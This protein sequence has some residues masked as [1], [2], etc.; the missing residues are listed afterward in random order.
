MRRADLEFIAEGIDWQLFRCVYVPEDHRKLVGRAVANAMQ[1][2]SAALGGNVL[3]EELT[4]IAPRVK[5]PSFEEED[6]WR[7][8]SPVLPEEF[9]FSYRV[10]R[11]TPV[12]YVPLP[13]TRHDN[14]ES[15]IEEVVVGPTPHRD[16]AIMA[17]A[18]Y[19]RTME[20]SARTI[21][22]G[23]TFREW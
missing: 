6:E 14:N 8:V 11:F 12:P 7:I 9:G 23:T 16:L 20:V 21:A 15:S 1:S 5:H 18:S 3:R 22:S 13:I 19:L 17:T 4:S 10:G 2:A